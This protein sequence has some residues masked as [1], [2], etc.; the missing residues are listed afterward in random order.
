MQTEI[1]KLVE[2]SSQADN[3]LIISHAKPDADTLGAAISIKLWLESFRKDVTLAC[4]DKPSKDFDFLPDVL[5]FKR[6]FVLADF[7]LMFVVDC[8]AS[9]L[10]EFDSKYPG[11]LDSNVPVINIDHH[12]SN[13]FFGD[14]NIVDS[15]SASTTLLLFNIFSELDFP[16]TISMATC[17]L[18][19]IYGDTGGFMHSNTTSEVLKVASV[20]MGLGADVR[21]ITASLFSN[22][23]VSSLRLWGKA[24]E[25]A[26]LTDEK[27]VLSVLKESDYKDVGSGPDQLTGLVDYLNMVPNSKF[28]VLIN[29][30][31][32]GNVKGSFRTR[33]DDVDLS[34]VAASYGGGGHSKAAGFKMPGRL[35]RDGEFRIISDGDVK[36]LE[37]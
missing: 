34:E 13:D 30:D 27:V 14:L 2:M 37:F 23:S 35:T 24:L 3:I 4:V 31:R 25:S 36:G 9:H 5:E 28:A 20:L 19:G 15:R 29:E 8:G 11:F 18:A 10:T 6:D 7:D 17:L 12:A 21:S 1:K 33:N 16:I 22:K 32:Q 26:V